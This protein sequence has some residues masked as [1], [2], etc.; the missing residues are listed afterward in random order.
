MLGLDL[1]LGLVFRFDAVF[2]FEVV[3][4]LDA[5]F[6][7]GLVFELLDFP[8]DFGFDGFL[9]TVSSNQ[10]VNLPSL[11]RP[12]TIGG[13]NLIHLIGLRLTWP[14]SSQPTSP[15]RSDIPR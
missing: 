2:L 15:A 13:A 3:F 12:T 14:R 9:A 5:V 10:A 7:L 8:F 4:L 11:S 6:D 1:G